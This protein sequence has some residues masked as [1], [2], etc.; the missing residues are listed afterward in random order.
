ME[1]V[2]T[3]TLRGWGARCGMKSVGHLECVCNET[4][5]RAMRPRAPTRAGIRACGCVRVCEKGH[6]RVCACA[7]SC[8]RVRDFKCACVRVHT[9]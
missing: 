8:V 3:E 2:G 9:C 7:M 4:S 1:S 6:A 5:F